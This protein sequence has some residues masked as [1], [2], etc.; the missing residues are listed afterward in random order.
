MRAAEIIDVHEMAHI[1][2][3]FPY[4][5]MNDVMRVAKGEGVR[6]ISQ[7]FDNSCRM[8]VEV[9]LDDA[10]LFTSCFAAVD[11]VSIID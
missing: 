7:E 4:L 11:G 2:F 3:T 8:T 5:A 10:P 6:I 1:E 9:R